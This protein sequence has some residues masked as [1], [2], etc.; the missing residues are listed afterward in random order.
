MYSPRMPIVMSCTPP[1]NI[2]IVSSVVKPVTAG[3]LKK[4]RR[5]M[6]NAAV[7]KPIAA[8]VKPR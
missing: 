6:K 1:M 2:I 5:T 8:Q 4:M 3:S 7:L